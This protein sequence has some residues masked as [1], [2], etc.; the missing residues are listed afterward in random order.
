MIEG[1][2]CDTIS[3]NVPAGVPSDTQVLIRDGSYQQTFNSTM[4]I[5]ATTFIIDIPGLKMTF[6]VSDQWSPLPTSQT[7]LDEYPCWISCPK[8]NELIYGPFDGCIDADYVIQ[9]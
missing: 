9:H 7:G 1:A 2:V 6:D 3:Y 5:Y 8:P 4:Q